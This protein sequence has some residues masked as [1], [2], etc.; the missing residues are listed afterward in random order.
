MSNHTRAVH[1]AINNYV[2][3][4]EFLRTLERLKIGIFYNEKQLCRDRIHHLTIQ[5][6]NDERWV[7]SCG[8]RDRS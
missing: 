4:A 6:L 2:R 7:D 8:Q 3:K 5:L 1:L